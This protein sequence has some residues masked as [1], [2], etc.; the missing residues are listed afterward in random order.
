MLGPVEPAL[1]RLASPD[2]LTHLYGVAGGNDHFTAWTRQ[3]LPLLDITCE[4]ERDGL[5]RIPAAD[6]VLL[7]ANHP[8]GLL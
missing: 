8:F 2:R 1:Q 3:L 4:F 7:V 5:S 6:P